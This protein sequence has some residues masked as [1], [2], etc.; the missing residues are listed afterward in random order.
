[1]NRR[2][3]QHLQLS[4]HGRKL[5]T[6]CPA[7]HHGY[8]LFR[9]QALAEAIATEGNYDLVVSSV[10]YDARNVELLHSLRSTGIEN[11]AADW[12]ALFLGRARFA[13][14]T[15]QEWVTWVRNHDADGH[16]RDWLSY[17]ENRYGYSCG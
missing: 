14:W 17:V 11:F 8:Q 4:D 6:C 7:A 2:Y 3:W 12:G 15:H 16:W 1:K 13:T 5:L 10:A 9:Q